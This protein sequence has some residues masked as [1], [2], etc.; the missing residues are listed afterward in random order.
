MWGIMAQPPRVFAS[1]RMVNVIRNEILVQETTNDN[2]LGLRL[3]ILNLELPTIDGVILLS[4]TE[5]IIS[6]QLIVLA[7]L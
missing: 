6:T 2:L 4:K 3:H 7:A 1:Q 5:G